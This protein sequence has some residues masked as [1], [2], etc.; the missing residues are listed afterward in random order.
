LVIGNGTNS[1]T[2]L[3]IG[4]TGQVL[5]VVSGSPAW[6]AAGGGPTGDNT[7]YGSG[8]GNSITTGTGNT[9]VG[10]RALYTLS[11]GNSATAVGYQAMFSSN[12]GGGTAVGY[13]A[14]YATTGPGNTAIGY[15]SLYAN[16]TGR[17]NVGIGDFALNSNTTGGGNTVINPNDSNGTTTPVFN[18]TTESNRFVCGSSNVTNA[19]IKVAWTV[20]SDV[21]DKA[22][23]NV[24][25]HGLDFVTKI[26]PIAF[27]YKTGRDSTETDG[28]V[29]YGFSAQEV[30]A[31]EGDTPV[32][33]DAENPETLRFNDQSLIAVLVNAIK[34]LTAR[35]KELEAKL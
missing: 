23:F 7:F 24:V 14:L 15:R 28:P 32:I 33:V 20:T 31:L 10:Y 4:T 18:P 26:N 19:Y 11:T 21:R 2:R 29:R 16:T 22:D 17:Y 34:E 30:L 25:P 1:A 35:V 5:T 12:I 6:A 9:G 27:R 8:A 13:Q 3:G